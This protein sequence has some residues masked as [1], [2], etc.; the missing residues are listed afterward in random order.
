MNLSEI[1]SIVISTI[2]GAA[3][4][5]IINILANRRLEDKKYNLWYSIKFH[6]ALIV[7]GLFILTIIF[8]FTMLSFQ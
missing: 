1:I 3:I 4:S 5:Q 2:M 7:A 6:L 8:L